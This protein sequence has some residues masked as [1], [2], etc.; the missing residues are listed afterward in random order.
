MTANDLFR[1]L[2][3]AIHDGF[4]HAE[5]LF[6]TEAKSFDYHMAKVGGAYLE[7]EAFP[8]RPFISL[9]EWKESK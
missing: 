8:D 2:E 3:L 9:H 7:T 1:I 5:I 6:D 4:G